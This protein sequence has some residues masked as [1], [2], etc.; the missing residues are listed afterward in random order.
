MAADSFRSVVGQLLAYCPFVPLPLVE[1]WARD[2][3]RQLCES[4][5][6]SFLRGKGNLVVPSLYSA[7]TASISRGT[8]VVIGAGTSWSA[9]MAGRQIKLGATIPVYTIAAVESSTSLTIEETHLGSSLADVSYQILQVYFQS[10]ADFL[11]W[12]SVINT[13][14]WLKFH[15]NTYT[16]EDIDARDPQRTVTGTPYIIAGGVYKDV[17]GSSPIP[18]FEIWPWPV[19]EDIFPYTYW[20]RTTDFDQNFY[21]PAVVTGDVLVTGMLADLCRW[22]GVEDRRNPMFSPASVE[23][24]ER[25]WVFKIGQCGRNDNEIYQTDIRYDNVPYA[26]PW[27]PISPVGAN[28]AQRHAVSEF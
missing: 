7:G 2:R 19:V 16:V 6:W 26:P 20:K 23:Q 18:M 15:C 10:P 11:S 8:S 5:K 17:V 1:L 14:N 12:I 3:W 25:L 4:R 24:Y 27:M 21:L 13:K 28:W 9:D 22:P